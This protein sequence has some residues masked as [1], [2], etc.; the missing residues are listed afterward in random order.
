M[1]KLSPIE[2]YNRD[3]TRDDFQYDAAQEN[4]VKCLQRL[5]DDFQKQELTDTGLT[6]FIK[7]WKKILTKSKAVPIKG[8]YFWGGVG[9]G[10]TYLVD[11]FYD[12][13]PFFIQV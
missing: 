10:K 3:L 4:A 13:L 7:S 12:S 2:Q 1:I 9:R 5:Y 6:K 8:L 11:T